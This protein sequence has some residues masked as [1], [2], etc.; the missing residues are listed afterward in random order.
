MKNIL[1]YLYLLFAWLVAQQQG[2]AQAQT[3]PACNTFS[4]EEYYRGDVFFNYGS[5]S[6]AFNP[7]QRMNTTLGQTVVGESFSQN[8]ISSF[9]YWS[10]LLLPPAAPVVSCSEGDL[11]D[12][13]NITWQPDPLSPSATGGFNIYR[14]N[15]LLTTVDPDA[16]SYVDFNVIAGQFYTYTVSG[17]NDFGEG[18]KN[19]SLGFLNPNGQ[20]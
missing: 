3:N 12:R 5:T 11:P 13:I 4:T 1:R 20:G 10:R 6:N 16:R 8:Y 2:L 7:A 17:K 9:G 15:V 14:D 18:F 19:A